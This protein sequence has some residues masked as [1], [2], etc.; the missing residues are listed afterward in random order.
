MIQSHSADYSRVVWTLQN[1][2]MQEARLVQ[3]QFCQAVFR[4]EVCKIGTADKK[5]IFLKPRTDVWLQ[6]AF[7]HPSFHYPG[8][9]RPL[10]FLAHFI[11]IASH[12]ASKTVLLE[13]IL[14]STAWKIFLEINLAM[15]FLSWKC[16]LPSYCSHPKVKAFNNFV[17]AYLPGFKL[18]N[19]SFLLSHFLSTHSLSSEI[20]HTIPS[21][22]SRL[23]F[24]LA[25]CPSGLS[26]D[27]IFGILNNF[28]SVHLP[29]PS[30]RRM[31]HWS[32]LY[33]SSSYYLSSSVV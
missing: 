14:N 20:A 22:W 1:S 3:C 32:A 18:I 4:R 33:A 28:F 24:S 16:F 11:S 30:S 31:P 15:S 13:A 17:L 7:L 23:S 25:I 10:F 21:S 29:A 5:P 6:T 9:G 19:S 27:L 26:L 2:F 8:S 12:L